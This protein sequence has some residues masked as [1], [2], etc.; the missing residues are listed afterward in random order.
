M[1]RHPTWS[2]DEE[3]QRRS[4]INRPQ[5][6]VSIHF[7]RQRLKAQWHKG[8]RSSTT[9]LEKEWMAP[10]ELNTIDA[11]AGMLS[12]ISRKRKVRSSLNWFA[13]FC[14]SKCL[15]HFAAPFIVV[16]AE[17]FVAEDLEIMLQTLTIVG[18]IT[19]AVDRGGYGAQDPSQDEQRPP[20]PSP[21]TLETLRRKGES[22]QPNLR[23]SHSQFEVRRWMCANDPSAGSPTETLLRLLLP[24]SDKVH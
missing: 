19:K 2:A 5:K 20:M 8:T 15:S 3:R 10:L 6:R 24:L 11:E 16:R 23:S 14:N 13:E 4:A 22:P 18:K 21:A 7:L 12:G 9:R 1:P 17:T